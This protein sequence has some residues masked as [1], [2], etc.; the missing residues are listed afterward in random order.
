M[1]ERVE[2]LSYFVGKLSVNELAVQTE[3]L[4]D[5][6]ANVRFFRRPAVAKGLR[7]FKHFQGHVGQFLMASVE[8]IE[9]E[10]QLGN[11]VAEFE[12]LLG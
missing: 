5:S 11:S 3:N 9:L 2:G 7:K 1:G 4:T 6:T 10:L 12:P 8:C